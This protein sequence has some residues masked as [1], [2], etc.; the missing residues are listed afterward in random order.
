MSSNKTLSDGA[1]QLMCFALI[2]IT[3]L[4]DWLKKQGEQ[5]CLPFQPKTTDIFNAHERPPSC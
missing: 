5:N 4:V 1:V 3:D 2:S